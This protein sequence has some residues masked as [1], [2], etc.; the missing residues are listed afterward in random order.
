MTTA[1][2]VSC[3][4]YGKTCDECDGLLIAPEWSA[5]VSKREVRHF[6]RCENCGHTMELADNLRLGASESPSFSLTA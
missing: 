2:F 1:R 4:S 6:W 3:S 5:H